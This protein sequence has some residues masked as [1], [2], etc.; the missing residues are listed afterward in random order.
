MYFALEREGVSVMLMAI[1]NSL[2]K[3]PYTITAYDIESNGLPNAHPRPALVN[4]AEVVR[5]TAFGKGD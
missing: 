1:L 4:M 5:G 3:G 2:P